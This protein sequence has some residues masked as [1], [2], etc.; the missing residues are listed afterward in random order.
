MNLGLVAIAAPLLLVV[1]GFM[2]VWAG[3]RGAVTVA[4][5]QTLPEDTP[6]RS[7]LVL[8][9]TFVAVGTLLVQGSAL[10]WLAG[11]LGLTGRDVGETSRSGPPSR[12]S[13]TMPPWLGWTRTRKL[14]PTPYGNG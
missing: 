11:R 6:Q 5:A 1:L 10:S 13:S 9:A 3:M 12:T 8:V 14:S 7:L 2:L 4:A